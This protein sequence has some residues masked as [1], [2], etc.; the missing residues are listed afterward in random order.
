MLRIS[1]FMVSR[2][3][4]LAK[5]HRP[6]PPESSDGICMRDVRSSLNLSVLKPI[7]AL[8]TKP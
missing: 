3:R 8:S 6:W 7:L 4:M 5:V 2:N 1:Y